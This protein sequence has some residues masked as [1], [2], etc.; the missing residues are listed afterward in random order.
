VA[1]RSQIACQTDGC[2][3]VLGS[4][5]NGAFIPAGHLLGGRDWWVDPDGTHVRCSRCNTWRTIRNDRGRLTLAI[6]IG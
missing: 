5:A 2:S 3:G 6:V 1:D 4:W